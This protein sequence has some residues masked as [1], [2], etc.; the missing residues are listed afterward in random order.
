MYWVPNK[1]PPFWVNGR[2]CGEMNEMI[3]CP[4][5]VDQLLYEEYIPA[6]D[7]LEY[8]RNAWNTFNYILEIR[9][10]MGQ[11]F[12]KQTKFSG[13][14]RNTEYIPWDLAYEE[15]STVVQCSAVLKAGPA[16]STVP[17]Y[18]R[19]SPLEVG[20]PVARPSAA[21]RP[22]RRGR[23]WQAEP[24]ATLRCAALRCS[25]VPAPSPPLPSPG[26]PAVHCKTFSG[27]YFERTRGL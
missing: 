17:S 20:T 26:P 27:R 23:R 18:S 10:N 3:G 11:H 12:A 4:R 25:R 14:L 19:Q 1:N 2:A 21:G 5:G 13:I 24:R 15:Y 8:F 7:I 9:P 6:R 16:Q 22:A